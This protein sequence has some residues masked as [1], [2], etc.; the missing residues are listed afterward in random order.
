M[1][2]TDPKKLNQRRRTGW[3]RE[4]QQQITF[5]LKTLKEHELKKPQYDINETDA[6]K[7]QQNIKA[8][9]AWATSY[10][11]LIRK[12]SN[13]GYEFK[14]DSERIHRESAESGKLA[15]QQFET[16]GKVTLGDLQIM[17]DS[18]QEEK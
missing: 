13:L 5:F 11:V 9:Q 7:Q 16:E 12:L 6:E 10:G 1:S 8:I 3:D 2:Y 15:Q 17:R 4:K 14:R 18:G